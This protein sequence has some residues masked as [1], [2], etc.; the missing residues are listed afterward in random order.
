MSTTILYH[1]NCNDGLI[2][3]LNFYAYFKEKDELDDTIF[4][5]VQYGEPL[6]DESILKV[7]EVY[8]VDFSYPRIVMT[9]LGD[10]ASKLILLDHHESTIH[11]LFTGE[12][13]IAGVSH[14]QVDAVNGD[15]L[16][17]SHRVVAYINK[18]RSGATMAYREVGIYIKD[19]RVQQ[20]LQYLSLR[21][22]DRDNWVFAYSD[23][24][25]VHEYIQSIG[26]DLPKLYDALFGNERTLE[27][28]QSGVSMA[29]IRVDMRDELARNYAGLAMPVNFMD[30]TVPV[31]NVPGGFASLVGDILDKDA[32]FAVTYVVTDKNIL[33]SM[34]SDKDKGVDVEE[35][36]RQLGGGGHQNASGCSIP[37]TELASFLKG[38]IQPGWI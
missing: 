22:E 30:H 29:Q 17:T 33:L 1:K 2:A 38:R 9:E 35:I 6:P 16:M 19:A 7:R 8:V 5:P 26:F 11:N 4:L 14:T 28:V 36:A 12:R 34:R 31:V 32:P 3:A 18:K 10:M 13:W 23:S 25:A 37:H 27:G 15:Y 20:T 21:A 24:K